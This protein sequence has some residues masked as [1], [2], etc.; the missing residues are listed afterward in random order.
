M[1]E[2]P[3]APARR[4]AVFVTGS[5]LRHVLVMTGSGALGLVAVFLVDFLTLLYVARLGD[6]QATAAVAFATQAM[7]IPLSLSIGMT[8]AVTA[9]VGRALGAGKVEAARRMAGASL[10]IVLAASGLASLGLWI[11]RA[12]FLAMVGAKG[13]AAALADVFLAIALPSGV[14]LSLGMAL[15]GVLRAAGDARRA[16]NVTLSA[17]VVTAI[18]DPILIFGLKMGLTGAAVTIGVG[19]LVMVFVGWRGA[20]GAHRL[21]GRPTREEIVADLR[22]FWAIAAPAIMTN[23][24]S[25]AASAFALAIVSRF[26]DGAVGALVMSDRV[27]ALAYAAI[28]ALSGSVGAILAQNLGAGR[29]D[30]LRETMRVCLTLATFYCIVMWAALHFA[31]PHIAALFDAPEGSRDLFGVFVFWGSAAW[32]MLGWLFVANASFNNLGFALLSTAF[33]WGRAVL[34]VIPFVWLGAMWDGARGAGIGMAAGSALF[35]A[36][37]LA[38]TRIVLNRIERRAAAADA[39]P[40]LE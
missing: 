22:P 23:L 19:R 10:T 40:R 13:E 15:S 39:A 7:F 36:A 1:S 6:P 29:I 32:I 16:M 31:A 33:N 35:G 9:V 11:F 34:G 26:G 4:P 25:P 12:A 14:L 18:L 17:A 38:T 37:A 30:R 2:A 24:A 28:F 20:Q 5:I 21:V 27:F 3:R 8:I